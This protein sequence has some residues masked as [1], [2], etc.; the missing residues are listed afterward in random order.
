MRFLIDECLS[1]QVARR[2]N[3]TGE[4]EA[5]YPLHV[6]RRGEDDEVVVARRTRED[7]IIVT[8]NAQ[9]F[10]KLVAREAIHPGLIIMPCVDRG[11]SWRL[12]EAAIL[13]LA[14]VNA[15]RPEDAIVNHVL[16]VSGE[17]ACTL[18]PLP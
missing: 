9:D 1:P 7:R 12:L 10:R 16:V 3:A 14:S 13:H 17:G 18:M 6:G 4:H 11:T 5:V 2:L 15:R 8:E